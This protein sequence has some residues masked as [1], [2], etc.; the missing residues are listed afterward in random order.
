MSVLPVKHLAKLGLLAL[1]A[2]LSPALQAREFTVALDIPHLNVAEYHRPYIAMWVAR[3]NN[4]VA[5][6]LSV[7]YDVG[8]ADEEG[9]KWLKD[10]R[11]WWRRSGRTLDMPV[12]GISGATRSQGHHDFDFADKVADLEPGDYR[13]IVEVV[14]EVGGREMVEIPFQ[15]PATESQRLNTSGSEEVG[16]VTLLLSP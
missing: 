4:R 15:W 8:L 3:E 9:E 7:L 2:A 16:E 13:L 14:R 6:N 10:I 5:T 12:D 11:Q 1:V